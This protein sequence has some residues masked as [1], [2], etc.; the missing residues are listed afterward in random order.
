MV[1]V[2]RLSI[3]GAVRQPGENE[4]KNSI[5]GEAACPESTGNTGSGNPQG[6]S[7]VN[8]PLRNPSRAQTNTFCEI[9]QRKDVLHRLELNGARTDALGYLTS[10]SVQ[11]L[12]IASCPHLVEM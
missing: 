3:Q 4:T 2:S 8:G 5:F 11:H 1:V 7:P 6:S 9:K 12:S 10:F